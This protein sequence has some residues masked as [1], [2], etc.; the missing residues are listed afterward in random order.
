MTALEIR[1]QRRKLLWRIT[2]VVLSL[3]MLVGGIT[4]VVMKRPFADDY[5]LVDQL[6]GNLFPS[7]ILSVAT[8]N[9]QVIPPMSGEY[10]VSYTHLTL[11]TS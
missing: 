5:E 11:P 7:A 1:I 2:A 9:T 10:A 4:Y 8:T 3:T 6:G